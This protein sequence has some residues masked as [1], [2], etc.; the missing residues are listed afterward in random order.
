VASTGNGQKG[1]ALW[2]MPLEGDRTP[3]VVVQPPSKETSVVMGRVSPDCKWVIYSSDE[4]GR[5]EVYLAPFPKGD[6]KWQVSTSGGAYPT[7]RADGKEIFWS[8]LD[9][10]FF[11]ATV[12]ANGSD[13]QVGVPQSLFHEGLIGNGFPYDVSADGQRFL[14]DRAEEATAAPLYLMVNWTAALKKQ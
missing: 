11:A 1:S 13:L 9:N 14:V 12:K 3:F 6:G 7:W 8:S 10:T 2:A 5:P 4:T